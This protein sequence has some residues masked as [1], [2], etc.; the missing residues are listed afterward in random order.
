M[1]KIAQ[2]LSE[3]IGQ[4]LGLTNLMAA[5]KDKTVAE[6]IQELISQNK[7]HIVDQSNKVLFQQEMKEIGIKRQNSHTVTNKEKS[8]KKGSNQTPS[9]QESSK[10]G[11]QIE[12]DQEIDE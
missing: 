3:K 11:P 6:Q 10:G 12:I 2:K 5:M 7:L 9:D 4:E 8:A 1:G